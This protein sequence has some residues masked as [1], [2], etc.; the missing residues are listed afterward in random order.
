MNVPTPIDWVMDGN[1]NV[2]YKDSGV[3]SYGVRNTENLAPEV[4]MWTIENNLLA[5]ALHTS[6]SS[7]TTHQYYVAFND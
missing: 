4:L 2:H 5:V 3:S 7:Q 1:I 6:A